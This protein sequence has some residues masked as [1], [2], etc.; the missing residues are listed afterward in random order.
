MSCCLWNEVL[1]HLHTSE[2]THACSTSNLNNLTVNKGNTRGMTVWHTSSTHE[3]QKTHQSKH[4]PFS[5]NNSMPNYNW[6]TESEK[7]KKTHCLC[8]WWENKWHNYEIS[9]RSVI[10]PSFVV[11]E[12]RGRVLHFREDESTVNHWRGGER[13]RDWGRRRGRGTELSLRHVYKIT[14][15]SHSVSFIDTHLDIRARARARSPDSCQSLHALTFWD[16]I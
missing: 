15:V 11:L 16:F 13:E 14:S 12:S 4:C 1:I 7:K 2:K 8:C 9:V 5:M 6:V 10:P 3:T